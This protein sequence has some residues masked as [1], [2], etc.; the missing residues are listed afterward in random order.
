[1]KA[2]I[3][4][5]YRH[6]KNKEQYTVLAIAHH[7]ETGEK[8]VV[9]QGHYHTDDLGDEP[10]FVRPRDMWEENVEYEGAVLPRFARSDI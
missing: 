1:M 10:I 5:K 8:L 4:K 3:G 9:Y 6:Y 2:E 7:T